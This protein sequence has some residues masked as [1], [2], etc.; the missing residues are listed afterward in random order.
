MLDGQGS[1]KADPDLVREL[2]ELFDRELVELTLWNADLVLGIRG[3]RSAT[4]S[5]SPPSSF[6]PEHSSSICAAL[7]SKSMPSGADSSVRTWSARS[8]W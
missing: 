3:I 5:Y 4:S 7:S 1:L 8:H 6:P 2:D